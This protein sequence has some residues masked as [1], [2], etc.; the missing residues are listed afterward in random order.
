[1]AG[2]QLHYLPPYSPDY[3]PIEEGFGTMKKWMKKHREDAKLFEDF[4]EFIGNMLDQF[5]DSPLNHFNSCNIL[6]DD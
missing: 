5:E 6:Q 3:N 4:G 2:V 1:M